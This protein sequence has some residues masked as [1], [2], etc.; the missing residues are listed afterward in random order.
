MSKQVLEKI[1][2]EKII[3]IVRGLYGE[4]LLSLAKAYIE[5]GIHCMEI[6]LDQESEENRNKAYDAMKLISSSLGD[7][8][9][10]GAGTVM[11]ADQVSKAVKAG[12]EFIISPNTDEQVIRDT[13]ALGKVSIPG[14]FTATEVAYAYKLG[15]HM[16]KLFPANMLGP[17]YI[18]S[19]KAPLKY[20]PILATGGVTPENIAEYLA[21]GSAGAGV[22]G[23]LVNKAWIAE[24]SFQKITQVAEA[25]VKGIRNAL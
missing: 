3:V 5:G 15:A 17:S 6:T 2:N 19:L 12:A 20:I 1:L 18:K 9:C 10:I 4:V 11:S 24:S 16:V 23:N 8:I 7:A 14:A 21:S 22:A 13:N 25:Y